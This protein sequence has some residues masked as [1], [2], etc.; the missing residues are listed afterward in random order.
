MQLV[1]DAAPGST[2]ESEGRFL[3]IESFLGM[4][5]EDEAPR[6]AAPGDR[7]GFGMVYFRRM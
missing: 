4:I 7:I 6:A 2:E 5:E 3:K 1:R